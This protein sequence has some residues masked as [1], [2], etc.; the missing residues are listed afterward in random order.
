MRNGISTKQIAD[1]IKSVG[2]WVMDVPTPPALIGQRCDRLRP[3]PIGKELRAALKANHHGNSEI[4]EWHW[5]QRLE[6]AEGWL[7]NKGVLQVFRW[8]RRDRRLVVRAQLRCTERAALQLL[9]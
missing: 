3:A 4:V 1:V 6:R 2:A 9:V 5:D 7:W 8:S